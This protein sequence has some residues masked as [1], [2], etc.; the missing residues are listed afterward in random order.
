MFISKECIYLKLHKKIFCLR[1][2]DQNTDSS[3]RIKRIARTE[4]WPI[5]TG[6]ISSVKIG[7]KG[8]NEF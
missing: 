6:E 1:L 7:V 2:K 8:F 3:I 5:L 4:D